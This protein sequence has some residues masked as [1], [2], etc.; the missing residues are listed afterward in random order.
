[1]TALDLEL[2]GILQGAFIDN[3][4]YSERLFTQMVCDGSGFYGDAACHN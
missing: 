3:G 4:N 1:L 2:S